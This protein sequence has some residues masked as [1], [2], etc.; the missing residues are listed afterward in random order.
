LSF[1]LLQWA[2]TYCTQ[3]VTFQGYAILFV[4]NMHA[5]NANMFPWYTQGVFKYE[6]FSHH[7]LYVIH[8]TTWFLRCCIFCALYVTCT[9]DFL[10]CSIEH[11]AIKINRGMTVELWRFLTL[12]LH[13]GESPASYSG[14]F[15][16]GESSPLG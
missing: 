5:S 2:P 6:D 4:S 1:G 16:I 9:E 12:K 15:N 3:F 11:C 13:G 10:L 8:A 14:Q 7:L